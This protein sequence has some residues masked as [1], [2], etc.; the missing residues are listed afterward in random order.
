MLSFVPRKA[1]CWV[2]LLLLAGCQKQSLRSQNPDDD[3]EIKAPETIFIADQ[4]AVSGLHPIQV[5]TVGI[6]T[7]LDNTGGDSPPSIWRTMAVDEMRRRGVKN[8]NTLLQSPSTALVIVRASLPP[9]IDVGD[10]FDVEVALPENTEA[11]SLQGGHLMECFLSEQAMVP[12]RA[13]MKGH[14]LGRA[15]GPIMLSTGEGDSASMASVVKRGRVLGGGVY[16]GG[17]LKQGRELGLYLRNDL[18]SVRQSRRIATAIGRRFHYFDHGIKKPLSKA[19]TDQFIELK[20]HPRYKENYV[21]YVQVI[22]HIAL[23][24]SAVEQKERMERLRK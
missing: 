6:V 22:R 19:K 3:D 13:P 20:V 23:N 5:E 8:P 24:E 10:H 11:T 15:E 4:V 1:A 2:L 21:R 7:G 9:V 16:K 18:R 17:I 12:G 14:V